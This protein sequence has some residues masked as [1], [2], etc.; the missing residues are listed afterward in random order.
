MSTHLAEMLEKRL[1]AAKAAKLKAGET[2][3]APWVFANRDGEPH[4]GDNLRKRVF[5]PA[6][7]KAKLRQVRI[8]DLRQHAGSRIMPGSRCGIG[9]FH[10]LLSDLVLVNSA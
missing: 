10:P 1:V 3:L 8:H 6:L 7:T 5:Q 4:D 9:L 2:D